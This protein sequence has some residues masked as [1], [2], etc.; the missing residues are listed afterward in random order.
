[1]AQAGY[2]L[3]SMTQ[4]PDVPLF[5]LQLVMLPS[6]LVPLHIFEPRYRDMIAFCT[7]HEA[8]FCIVL[9]D[10]AGMRDVGCLTETIEVLERLEDGRINLVAT[11]GE[12]VRIDR[13]DAD[14]HTY[15]SAEVTLQPDDPD[16][17]PG[18]EA[19]ARAR[20]SYQALL[21]DADAPDDET[22]NG[23]SRLSYELAARVEFPLELK[24]AL[25]ESR[26]EDDR[27]A[28]VTAAIEEGRRGI[29]QAAE[30]A[31]R[32]TTNGKVAHDD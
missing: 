1:M 23:V 5:P 22:V 10:A 13:L 24:Q 32:A 7:D 9:V 28:R 15:L 21:R 31:R 16:A 2:S 11:G 19:I 3:Q 30:R 18:A 12:V 4:L 29:R 14:R 6:E 25:L 20:E 26:S 17:R 8:P 27:L